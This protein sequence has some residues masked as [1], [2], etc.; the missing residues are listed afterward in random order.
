M[1]LRAGDRVRWTRNDPGS[2]LVNGEAAAVESIE[3]E[4]VRFR[5]ENGTAAGLAEGD[6]QLRHMD[7]AWA[8]TVHAFQGRTVDRIV[9]AMPAGNPNL[10]NQRAFYVVISRARDHAELVTDD[11]RK[12]SDQLERATGERISALD[13]VAKEAAHEAELGLEPPEERD[14]GHADRMDREHET[15]FQPDPGHGREHQPWHELDWD[16]D[17]KSPER[18]AG[19]DGD[20]LES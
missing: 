4:G 16:D 14:A 2:N 6:P 11:A 10:T 9:A 1:E 12:L 19:R 3:K 18:S 13:G 8:A 15:E 7:R 20:G 5:L 17:L